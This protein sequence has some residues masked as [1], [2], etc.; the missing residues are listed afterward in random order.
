MSDI[1]NP[2]GCLFEGDEINLDDYKYDS[3][4]DNPA[5]Y[6][7][8]YKKY[9]EGSLFGMWLDLTSFASAED[10]FQVCR[11]LHR[12]EADPELMFQDYMNFPAA[13]Y[14][15]CGMDEDKFSKILEYADLDEDEREA[16]E[17]YLDDMNSNGSISDFRESYN[18]HWDSEEEFA[19][20]LVD[21]LSM[22]SDAPES[23]KRFFDYK[24]FAREL[25]IEDYYMSDNGH[26]FRRY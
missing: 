16:Y 23:L 3:N 10:F 14:S 13:W 4:T 24:K 17:D 22:L 9:N 19:E 20:N 21:E 11:F 7:G 1:L 5:L 25:F 2:T 8:T 15:E 18:G 26:V 12:D 6:V